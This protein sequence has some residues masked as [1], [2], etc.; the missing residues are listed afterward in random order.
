MNAEGER[1]ELK[2][3]AWSTAL[4]MVHVGTALSCFTSVEKKGGVGVQVSNLTAFPS[5]FC[6]AF[7][8]VLL[9]SVC[10]WRR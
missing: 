3:E 10:V 9:E 7:S 8:T 4:V 5:G 6:H 2:P 1:T